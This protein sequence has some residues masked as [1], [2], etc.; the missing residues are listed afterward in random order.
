MRRSV[1]LSLA[2]A[3]ALLVSGL[4]THSPASFAQEDDTEMGVGTDAG[5]SSAPDMPA[6]VGVPDSTTTGSVTDGPPAG[7][8]DVLPDTP[9]APGLVTATEIEHGS[10]GA[11]GTGAGSGASSAPGGE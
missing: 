8:V 3:G 1:V 2:V 4:A 10:S 6:V 9:S 5:D 11:A 7:P